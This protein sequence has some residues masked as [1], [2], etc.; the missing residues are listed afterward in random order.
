MISDNPDSPKQPHALKVKAWPPEI[1]GE[2]LGILGVLIL[3]L[4]FLIVFRPN[5][6]GLLDKAHKAE[7]TSSQR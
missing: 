2:G 6:S 3:A 7:A 4:I 5:I 1:S